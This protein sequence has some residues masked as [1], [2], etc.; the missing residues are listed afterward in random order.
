M[1]SWFQ[2]P[3]NERRPVGWATA[4]FFCVLFSYL[5]V[6]PVRET[7]G[8]V[9]GREGLQT[10]MFVTLAAMLV[11]VPAYAWL[12]AKLP[13]RWLVR[14]VYHFFVACLLLFFGLMQIKSD[15]LDYWVPRVFFV[16]VN[17]FALYATSVFWSV[18]A[19]LFNSQSGKRLFG[20]IA[21]GGTAGA[22]SGS[23]TASQVASYIPTS[24]LLLV[25]AATIEIGL[26]FAWRLE[27]SVAANGPLK[28]GP[29]KTPGAMST[30]RE[31][32]PSDS[33]SQS[34]SEAN[35]EDSD[36]PTSGLWHGVLAVAGSPYLALICLF[37][38][39]G[40]ALGTQLYFQQ[41]DIVADVFETKQERIELFA[42]LD[43]GTQLLTL[44]IQS[45]LAGWVLRKLGI[46]FALVALPC[47]YFL[48]CGSLAI[49]PTL[50]ILIVGMIAT[51]GVTYGLTVPA[52]EVLFTV[53]SREDKY[54]SKSFID[55]VVLR[56]GDALSGSVFNA[57]K[58]GGLTS[59]MLNIIVLPVVALWA[60]VAWQLG[61]RQKM[62]A[63]ETV[64]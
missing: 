56:G 35:P 59:T 63:H 47:I 13:R 27:K 18:L 50:A 36:K 12:V 19:D 38:L 17:V 3:A 46:A 1:S 54:K 39:M 20:L 62:L 25:P 33:D 34:P 21:A 28:P 24:W 6:R 55:T 60:L 9:V 31:L 42:Y 10:L 52:R 30:E 49:S 4:W 48:V 26:C 58:E 7:M 32:K 51:R 14:C 57:A 23:F 43:L 5:V 64:K 15:S 61:K 16:W 2:I 53:V 37:L 8:S 29:D 41:A 11:A 22:I 40:Q 44:G 45:L